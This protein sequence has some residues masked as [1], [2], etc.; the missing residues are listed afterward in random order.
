MTLPGPKNPSSAG[1]SGTPE[2][3]AA[4][5][6]STSPDAMANASA[7]MASTLPSAGLALARRPGFLARFRAWSERA[8]RGIMGSV[9]AARRGPHARIKEL[10]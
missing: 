10:P 4:A 1:S 7:V 3:N 8:E 9:L 2:T 5:V 6:R